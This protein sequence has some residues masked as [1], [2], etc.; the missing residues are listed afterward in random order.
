MYKRTKL[1]STLEKFYGRHRDLVNPCNVIVSRLTSDVF[2]T[3]KP[4]HKQ[5]FF[6]VFFF[7]VFFLFVL[8]CFNPSYSFPCFPN[9]LFRLIGIVGETCLSSNAYFP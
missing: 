6:F 7:F 3:S 1:V 9:S 8:F 2:A 5:F 4:S